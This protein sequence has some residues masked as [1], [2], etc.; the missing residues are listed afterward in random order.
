VQQQAVLDAYASASRSVFIFNVP[1]IALCLLG[2][3]I[4]KDRGLQR[5]EEAIPGVKEP[6]ATE[7]QVDTKTSQV[8]VGGKR[9]LAA[10]APGEKENWWLKITVQGKLQF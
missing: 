9:E 3:L 4:V 10:E 1:F 2:C 8:G 5:P 6:H 7:V